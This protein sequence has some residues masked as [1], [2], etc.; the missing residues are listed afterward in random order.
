MKTKAFIVLA[1]LFVATTICAQET[2]K[3]LPAKNSATFDKGVVINGI[4]WATRNVDA[5]GTFAETPESAGMFYQWNRK[6]GWS[7]TEPMINSNGKTKWNSAIPK[8]SEWGKNNDPTPKGWRIPTEKERQSLFDTKQVSNEWTTQN[9]VT[10]RKF[11]DKSTG[12][13]IFLPAAGYRLSGDGTLFSAG[14]Y[15]GYW[16]STAYGRAMDAAY[17][18]LFTSRH[19]GSGGEYRGSGLSVRAVAE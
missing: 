10:G 7:A 16:S 18:L 8:G 4:T 14:T 6:I 9:G 5:P 15:G 2:E 19:T 12:N 17:Y 1:A 3:T 13:S 11:T